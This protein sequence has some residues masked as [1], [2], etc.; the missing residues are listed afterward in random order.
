MTPPGPDRDAG[1]NATRTSPFHAETGLR[2]YD[3]TILEE[4][5]RV[6]ID[7]LADLCCASIAR[8]HNARKGGRAYRADRL[9]SV[10]QICHTC[11]PE[12]SRIPTRAIFP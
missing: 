4:Y 8:A 6:L 2:S 1:R 7:H 9:T 11:V 12:G 3:R 10:R 5:N